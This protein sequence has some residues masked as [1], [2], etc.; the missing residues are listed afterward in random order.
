MVSFEWGSWTEWPFFLRVYG[1]FL[2]GFGET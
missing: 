1:R 2:E